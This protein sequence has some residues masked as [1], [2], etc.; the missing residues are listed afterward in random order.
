MAHFPLSADNV[1]CLCTLSV[2]INKFSD[3]YCT[4]VYGFLLDKLLPLLL[5]GLNAVPSEPGHST[6]NIL[7]LEYSTPGLLDV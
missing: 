4:I 5:A 1:V 7:Q 2:F 6:E 3:I